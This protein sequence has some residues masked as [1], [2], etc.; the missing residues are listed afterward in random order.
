MKLK[1]YKEYQLIA[2]VTSKESASAVCRLWAA[3]GEEVGPWGPVP[4]QVFPSIYEPNWSPL[5]SKL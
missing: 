2:E 3:S 5:K 4:Y 1:I